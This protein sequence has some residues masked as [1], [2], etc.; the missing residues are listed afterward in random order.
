MGSQHPIHAAPK[1]EMS[2]LAGPTSCCRACVCLGDLWVAT[3]QGGG[4]EELILE[5]PRCKEQT[6]QRQSPPVSR[7]PIDKIGISPSIPG[8]ALPVAAI[9]R[10]RLRPHMSPFYF[11]GVVSLIHTILLFFCM[12]CRSKRSNKR[13]MRCKYSN[14]G[15][16]RLPRIH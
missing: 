12:L 3:M 1:R 7:D 4:G 2:D 9:S 14:Q 16:G 8:P 6:V 10:A 15:S 11:F 5:P 13:Q